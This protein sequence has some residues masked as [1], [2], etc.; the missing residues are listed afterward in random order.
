MTE[1]LDR[2]TLEYLHHKVTELEVKHFDLYGVKDSYGRGMNDAYRNVIRIFS[3]ILSPIY[4]EERREK[5]RD[6]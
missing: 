5:K 6:D 3:D 4:W 1:Q 2:K